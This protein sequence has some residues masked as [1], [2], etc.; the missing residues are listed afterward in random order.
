MVVHDSQ[1]KSLLATFLFDMWIFLACVMLFFCCTRRKNAK[2]EKGPGIATGHDQLLA[3][4][5]AKELKYSAKTGPKQDSSQV[6]PEQPF[7]ES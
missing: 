6:A 4:F 3:D 2:L 1:F 7:D 5:D